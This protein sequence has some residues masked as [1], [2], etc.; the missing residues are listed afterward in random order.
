MVT[1]TS[2]VFPMLYTDHQ[3]DRTASLSDTR[4]SD[5]TQETT[6]VWQEA[7][8]SMT[9]LAVTQRHFS[10]PATM[11]VTFNLIKT[12]HKHLKH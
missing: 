1:Q 5:Q 3:T 8:I 7:D 12:Q 2:E 11:Q 10:Y 4:P 6:G 9:I